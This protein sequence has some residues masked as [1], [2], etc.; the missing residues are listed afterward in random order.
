[1]ELTGERLIP[2][3]R[4]AT[5]IALNDPGTLQ[6][7]IAGC[8]SLERTDDGFAAVVAVRVGPVSAKFKGNLK[9]LDVRPPEGYTLQFEGQGGAAGFGKGS[10]DVALA[11]E[12]ASTR[13]RYVAKASVGG[14]M[15]QIGSRLVDA[16]ASK[17]AEDFFSAFE[18]RVAATAAPS[19]APAADSSGSSGPPGATLAVAEAGTPAGTAAGRRQ[20]A[21][22][23]LAVAAAIVVIGLYA[24]WR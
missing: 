10:A 11:E 12:G 22:I 2:A 6:A 24:A 19:P 17:I 14:K 4:A 21:W 13:L 8:E 1:M 3:P 9:L 20:M 15:A 5:W 16:A 7:C 23:A 18:A